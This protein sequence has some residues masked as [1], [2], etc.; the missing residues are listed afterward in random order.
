[1]SL[2]GHCTICG[3]SHAAAWRT[4]D[5]ERSESAFSTYCDDCWPTRL[6]AHGTITH[7]WGGFYSGRLFIGDLPAAARTT[8][9]FEGVRIAV[10]E[11]PPS[12]PHPFIHAPILA[13]KPHPVTRAGALVDPRLL[14]NAVDQITMNLGRDRRVLVHCKGGIERSPLVV[15]HF[16][17]AAHHR[18]TLKGAYGYLKHIRPAIADRRSW[19]PDYVEGADT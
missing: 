6:A 7:V 12:Y 14:A 5:H 3:V 19:L 2:G 15:A 4:D 13:V 8:D 11:D 10:H 17:V 18:G 1:V 16:L 9:P